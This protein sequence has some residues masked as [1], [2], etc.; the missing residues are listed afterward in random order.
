MDVA[1]RRRNPDQF[2]DAPNKRQPVSNAHV[3]QTPKSAR[4]RVYRHVAEK[5]DELVKHRF[6]IINL[7]RAIENPAVDWPLALCDFRSVQAEK[8]V[9]PV[10]LIYPERTGETYGVRFNPEH[11]WKYFHG[12]TPEEAILIKW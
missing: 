11:K 10:T 1:I 3:D 8:D 6:Q 12:A 7:W 9:V 2:D 4:D 5:A